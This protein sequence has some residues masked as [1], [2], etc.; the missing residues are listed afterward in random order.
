MIHA[1]AGHAEHKNFVITVFKRIFYTD[2][3]VGI[4]L[5][6][7]IHK[8]TDWFYPYAASAEQVGVTDKTSYFNPNGTVSQT[9][10]AEMAKKAVGMQEIAENGAYET[11]ITRAEAAEMIYTALKD[12][13]G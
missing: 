13:L 6:D 5:S 8:L 11:E 12:L 7:G 1:A 9:E 3:A 2:F 4:I 10:A